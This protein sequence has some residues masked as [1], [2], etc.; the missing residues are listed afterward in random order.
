MKKFIIITI[1]TVISLLGGAAVYKF[2][3]ISNS[4]QTRTN[5]TQIPTSVPKKDYPLFMTIPGNWLKNIKYTAAKNTHPQHVYLE[6]ALY[7]YSNRLGT[8]SPY[9]SLFF[10]LTGKPTDFEII[11]SCDNSL[12]RHCLYGSSG[13][14]YDTK[15][16]S[17]P[18]G[19]EHELLQL[20]TDTRKATGKDPRIAI[21]APIAIVEN[22][23]HYGT[24]AYATTGDVKIYL[25]DGVV[26]D[27]NKAMRQRRIELHPVSEH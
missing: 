15:G 17:L 13:A 23:R 11:I 12:T 20:V 19:I 18:I 14:Q 4:D 26:S 1:G 2:G 27:H 5:G 8:V 7:S 6:G 24:Y 9:G 3:L 25:I 16:N 21:D 22:D 10:S